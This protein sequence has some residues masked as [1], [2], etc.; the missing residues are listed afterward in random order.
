[1]VSRRTG[2]AG[3]VERKSRVSAAC[4]MDRGLMRQ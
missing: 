4:A 1:M 3:G 2:A